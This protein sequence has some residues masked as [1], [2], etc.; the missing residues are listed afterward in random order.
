MRTALARTVRVWLVSQPVAAAQLVLVTAV[1]GRALV[2]AGDFASV[3]PLAASGA[4]AVSPSAPLAL[5]YV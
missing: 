1:E 4:L 3:L 2:G 5:A